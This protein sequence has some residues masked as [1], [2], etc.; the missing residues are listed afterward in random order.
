MKKRTLSVASVSIVILAIAL[1]VVVVFIGENNTGLDKK[2]T[3]GDRDLVQSL[4]GG[5]ADFSSLT[6][7]YRTIT[8]VQKHYLDASR[9]VPRKML[10]EAMKELE[11]DIA[12][13]IAREE[14]DTLRVKIGD[15]EKTFALDDL[16]TPWLLLSRFKDIFLFIKEHVSDESVDFNELQYTAINGMLK[17]LDP[18]TV[19]LTPDVYRG[20]KDRTHGNFGGLGIVISIRDGNLTIISPIDG[21]PAQRAGLKAGDIISKIDE[22]STINMPIND[23]VDL[24]RGEP[25]TAVTLQIQRKNWSEEK[26]FRIKR[27]II[28][29]RSIDSAS[30]PG[31]IGYIRIHDFQANTAA[32]LLDHL[33]KMSANGSLN[34]LVLDLRS[35]P[36]GLLTAAIDVADIFLSEGVIVTTAGQ[37][38]SERKVQRA[39]NFGSEPDYPIVVLVNSG[40]ASASEIVAGA[41]KGHERAVI[42]GE[43]TFGK[44]SVQVL[45]E[46]EDNSALKLTTA[47]YLTPGDISIQSVGIVPHVELMKMRADKQAIHLKQSIRYREGDLNHHIENTGQT[48]TDEAQVSLKYLYIP[49]PK[50]DAPSESE[51]E[52]EEEPLDEEEDI[53]EQ[54]TYNFKFEPDFEINLARDVALQL[55]LK[56]IQN[57][58]L[59]ALQEV[60]TRLERHEKTKLANALR[61]LGIDWSQGAVSS[62]DIRVH[63]A[64]ASPKKL[65]AG[66]EN[67]LLVQVENISN[68]P[69]YQLLATTRSDFAPLNQKELA[70]GKMNPGQKIERR[71]PFKIPKNYSTR[72]DDVKVS[73]EDLAENKYTAVAA[74][75][76]ITALPAPVFA[77]NTFFMDDAGNGDGLLQPGETIRLVASIK[78]SGEGK[79]ESV[80]ANLTNESGNNIFLKKG[81]QKLEEIAPGEIKQAEFEFEVKKA[82][83]KRDVKLKL[84]VMDVELRVFTTQALTYPVLPP[85][86]VN[87]QSSPATV[88]TVLNAILYSAPTN[89]PAT[90]VLGNVPVHTS[91]HVLAEA[92]GYLK[93]AIDETR[94]AWLKKD[95][96]APGKN[97]EAVSV[98]IHVNEPPTISVE[99]FNP[100]VRSDHIVI[101]GIARDDNT[102]KDLYIFNNE[103]K[104]Y[105][106]TNK[107]PSLPFTASVPLD[108]GIN[109][110]T[111]IAEET[112][113]LETRH[114]FVIRRDKKD[115]MPYISSIDIEGTPEP[116]GILPQ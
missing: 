95:T 15:A 56:K 60:F 85:F 36:G 39:H 65:T 41:L 57:F 103:D 23:A 47:Q 107:G 13:L 63:T 66:D 37:K 106:A 46:F 73:F 61:K 102:V 35:N 34:G 12:M 55:K 53:T 68:A 109:F 101:K 29:V 75:F 26:K 87:A 31:K 11:L 84:T 77:F 104:V 27:A 81:R 32:D 8:L 43:R 14:G 51:E 24:M 58:Q 99:S 25:G 5:E 67:E 110:V 86:Q 20:M 64:I 1:S 17:A 108:N 21:T 49:E 3:L 98:S 116:L 93:I 92:N 76:S 2:P 19:L 82:F 18:H 112:A 78:N 54:T 97:E 45:N 22:A 89:T 91:V 80:F 71:L 72:T 70:F 38:L 30:M 105:F 59:D 74:R 16:K 96:T 100:V 88:Q 33:N 113:D 79:A 9:I 10:L 52:T 94:W 28:K 90:V 4:V 69:V 115:G 6:T 114:T 62:A 83:A 48:H 42:I 50:E 40:T 111:I 44:G 7:M